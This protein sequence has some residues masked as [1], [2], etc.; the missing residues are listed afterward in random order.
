MSRKYIYNLTYRLAALW[1]RYGQRLLQVGIGL[2]LAATIWK[3][4]LELQQLI[5]GEDYPAAVDLGSRYKEVQLWF[6]GLP[7]YRIVPDETGIFPPGDY[8]PA[9][10]TILWPLVGWLPLPTVRWLWAITMLLSLGWL[11]QLGIQGSGVT[12][13]WEQIF[14]ALLGFALY[15]TSVSIGVGQLV[16]H[17][18]P[19]LV[20][21]LIVMRH[22][23][24]SWQRD[25][26]GTL[27]LLVAMVK[28]ILSIP[29]FWF[30]CFVYR[31]WRPLIMFIV[32][33]TILAMVA[34]LYQSGNLLSLHFA[35]LAHAG[36][37][38]ETKGHANLH[39][40]L[41]AAGYSDWMLPGSILML[42]IL[43]IWMA[44]YRQADLWVLMGVTA[45]VARFWT[46]HQMYDD[47]LLWIPMIGLLRLAYKLLDITLSVLAALLFGLNW[48]ALMAPARFINAPPPLST[49]FTGGQTLL[50]LATLFFLGAMAQQ[51]W[52]SKRN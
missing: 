47:L 25:L 44:Y 27:L 51:N 50:W 23:R 37:Y 4:S 30:V 20:T 49:V 14:V 17:T 39:V 28:P 48:L 6:A 5:W 33:Y 46:D 43:G 2:M 12:G 34:I 31:R 8:P 19:P 32:G 11:A 40:W 35:W 21:G 36:A 38:L 1:S 10:Y 22:P 15:P 45:L 41:E 29:F 13:L 7:V 16:V 52:I 24:S 9:S 26:L 18:V 3:F 42:M